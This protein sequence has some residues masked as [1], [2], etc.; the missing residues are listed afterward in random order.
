MDLDTKAEGDSNLS[1]SPPVRSL[2]LKSNKEISVGSQHIKLN[3]YFQS[4]SSNRY[5]INIVFSVTKDRFFFKT[6]HSLGQKASFDTYKMVK[7]ISCISLDHSGTNVDTL[8]S[9]TSDRLGN[10]AFGK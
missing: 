8:E 6:E 9:K 1:L 4:I 5:K 2:T 10:W 7:I 3:K